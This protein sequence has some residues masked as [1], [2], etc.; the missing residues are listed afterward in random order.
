MKLFRRDEGLVAARLS[1][2][3]S[4][5]NVSMTLASLSWSMLPKLL[6]EKIVFSSKSTIIRHQCTSLHLGKN[7]DLLV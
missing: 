6:T 4:R 2:S 3:A 1:K 7:E 5:K